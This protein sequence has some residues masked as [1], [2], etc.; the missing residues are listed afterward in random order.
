MLLDSDDGT[1]A[2]VVLQGLIKHSR[3]LSQYSRQLLG[4][5]VQTLVHWLEG[6]MRKRPKCRLSSSKARPG[7]AEVHETNAGGQACIKDTL[8]Q[9]TP[10]L[11]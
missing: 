10:A 6:L 9:S 2:A 7:G 5:W 11:C 3:K 4:R 8:K 1:T